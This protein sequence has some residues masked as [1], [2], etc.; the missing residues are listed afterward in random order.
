VINEDQKGSERPLIAI[1]DVPSHSYGL[2]EESFGLF[3]ACAAA[4]NAYADAR[5]A[6]HPVVSLVVG[7]AL[8]GA[9]LAH[10]YQS[11]R[12]LAFDDPGAIIHAMGKQAAARVTKRS[13][14]ELDELAAKVVPLSYDIR[15]YAQLGLVYHLIENVNPDAPAETDIAKV[16]QA[17]QRAILDARSCPPDLSSRLTSP[18][19]RQTRGASMKVRRLLTSQWRTS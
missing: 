1:V 12:I 9:F 6:G 11:N 18:Q 19:A 5:F 4:A 3:L 16:R 14:T 17:L 2:L 7:R 15:A 10:G 13:L 8:S